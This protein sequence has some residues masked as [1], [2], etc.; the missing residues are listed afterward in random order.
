M[1]ANFSPPLTL[2]AYGRLL[3]EGA[4]LKELTDQLLPGEKLIGYY[5]WGSHQLAP[6]LLPE[7]YAKHEALV[8]WGSV[9]RLGFYAVTEKVYN[10]FCINH[11]R[12]TFA[13]SS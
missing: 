4:T 9:K 11:P 7:A 2:P 12:N 5:D 3:E 8:R 6:E 13:Y 1:V 10:R